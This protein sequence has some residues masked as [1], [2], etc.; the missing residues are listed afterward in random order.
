MIVCFLAVSDEFICEVINDSCTVLV[1]SVKFCVLVIHSCD[2]LEILI[3]VS[4][5]L[6]KN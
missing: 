1:E 5:L 6:V 4:E 3:F 2:L